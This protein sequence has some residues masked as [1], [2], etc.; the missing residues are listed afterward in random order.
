MGN[1][2]AESHA[3]KKAKLIKQHQKVQEAQELV[4]LEARI[5]NAKT[6]L[7]AM[8][9]KVGITEIERNNFQTTRISQLIEPPNQSQNQA[10]SRPSYPMLMHS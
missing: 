7:A 6:S 9:I 4:E 8:S 10:D 5:A 1:C 3:S 2:L